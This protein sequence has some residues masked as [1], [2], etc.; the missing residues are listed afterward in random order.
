[1]TVAP[2]R[3]QDYFSHA[4]YQETAE[5]LSR[6]TRQS[7]GVLLILG[8]GLGALADQVVGADEVPYAEL[9]HWP[10]S[11]V[12]GHAGRLVIGRLEGQTVA[13]M[14][15]RAHYYEGYS[16]AHITLP[17]RVLRLM[18]AHTL[19]VTNAA[20]GLRAGFKPG[21]V[22]LLTDHLN[23]LGMAGHNPLRGPNDEAFGPRFPDM[24]QVYDPQLRQLAAEAATGLGIELQQGVYVCLAGPSYETPAD[25]RF[26]RMA[27]AD[28]VGMSTAPEATVARHAG[29]RVLGFSGIT[30][31][32]ARPGEPE[33]THA[34]VLQAGKLIGPRLAGII[35]GVLREMPAVASA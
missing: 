29:M 19:I 35:R 33:T 14:Q 32:P 22:M 11:T 28:A 24:S 1:M 4:Q 18:G 25:L 8:S 10:L 34:E 2:P 3:T 7:P 30:N 23:L 31:T 9:P 6:R 27:G 21:D 15:G 26:L 5:A 12:E 17:V 16:M 13:V 20:G